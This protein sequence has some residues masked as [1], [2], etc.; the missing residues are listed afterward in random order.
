MPMKT[1]KNVSTRRL[2]FS[3]P[4]L[5]TDEK[6]ALCSMWRQHLCRAFATDQWP[7]CAHYLQRWC[8]MNGLPPNSFRAPVDGSHG[9]RS[10]R[11]PPRCPR[12]WSLTRSSCP[13]RTRCATRRSWSSWSPTR[14]PPSS[15][16]PPARARVFTSPWVPSQL[17]DCRS[18]R[19]TMYGHILKK[20]YG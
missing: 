20:I 13:R 6:E 12:T 8:E 14:S 4:F 1:N 17:R 15:S 11:A 3:F 7:V 5:T 18:G 10:W 2:L 16:A 19:A 9:R